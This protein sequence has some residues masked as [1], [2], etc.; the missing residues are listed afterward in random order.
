M[1]AAALQEAL[2]A[3][4]A[5]LYVDAAL[6]GMTSQSSSAGLYTALSQGYEAHRAQRD[7]LVARLRRLGATPVAAEA[8]YDL[9]ADL[10]SPGR[11]RAAA[12]AVERA[13][14][15]TY[16]TVVAGSAGEIRAESLRALRASALR[17]LQ[18]GGEPGL[19]PGLG[20]LDDSD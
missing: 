2:A 14:T 16:A 12:L 15:A 18:F 7:D 8:V 13:C 10:S 3:E 9:P 17:E 1:S 20:E 19:F 4:H 11:I 6:G 5:A